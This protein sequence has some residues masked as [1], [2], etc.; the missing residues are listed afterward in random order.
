MEFGIKVTTPP[1][2]P[3]ESDG[4]AETLEEG[5]WSYETRTYYVRLRDDRLGTEVGKGS[6]EYAVHALTHALRVTE[7]YP[8][9]HVRHAVD[10]ES[11]FLY[12]LPAAVLPHLDW[13]SAVREAERTR[14][15]PERLR[16]P[17]CPWPRGSPRV[18]R[19]LVRR[20]LR[21]LLDLLKRLSLHVHGAV[22]EPSKH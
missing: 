8:P 20:Y 13:E 15:E 21:R 18:S 4:R 3:P 16:L 12:E 9:A 1:V 2:P 19:P 17:T 14:L 6:A 7:G 22:T 5:N 11:I 10:E